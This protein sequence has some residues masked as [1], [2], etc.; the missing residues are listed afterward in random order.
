MAD[1]GSQVG[2]ASGVRYGPL[3]E[4]TSQG[5]RH[6][7]GNHTPSKCSSGQST[8]RNILANGDVEIP[9]HLVDK[10]VPMNPAGIKWGGAIVPEARRSRRA[11]QEFVFNIISNHLRS[12]RSY[13]TGK[14]KENCCCCMFHLSGRVAGGP[15]IADLKSKSCR[16]CSTFSRS[17]IC[18]SVLVVKEQIS[19]LLEN[20]WTLI[21]DIQNWWN[22]VF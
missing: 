18:W 21:F 5:V 6:W 3:Q 15:L 1:Q 9:S 22:Y 10:Q 12:D 8:H 20:I 14:R 17:W 11:E 4:W 13:N 19:S 16:E 2:V 7:Q